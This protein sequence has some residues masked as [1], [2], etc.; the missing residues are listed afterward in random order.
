MATTSELGAGLRALPET[1]GSFAAAQAAWRFYRNPRL[2]LPALM[3][4]LLVEA[5]SAIQTDC[6]RY[7][8]NVNDW[9]VLGYGQHESK[10]D[11]IPLNT[12]KPAG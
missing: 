12:K 2:T 10:T 4:P 9:S 3:Q 6:Q 11:R 7:V 1:K 8:L 5:R